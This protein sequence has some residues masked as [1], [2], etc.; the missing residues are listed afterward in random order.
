MPKSPPVESGS[1]ERS[2]AVARVLAALEELSVAP[3]PLSNHELAS[4][5]GVPSA[6]MYRL[7][8]KL[9]ELGYVEH[10]ATHASYEVAP[11]LADLAERLA[12]AGC[13][14]PPLRRLLAALRAEAGDHIAIWVRSGIQVRVAALL[15]GE[16]R[17]PSSSA[18]R[19]LPPF[20]TPGLAIASQYTREQVRALVAQCRRRRAPFGRRFSGIADIEKTLRDVRQRGF[21]VGYNMRSDGW[22]ILAWPVVVTAAPLRIGALTI[23]AP[24]ATLRREEARLVQVAQRLVAGYHREQ[25]A[26]GPRP[27]P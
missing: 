20:S 24:V 7:L 2:R 8:Q 26:A 23:G 16:V 18:F 12:D 25:A 5:L 27:L 9:A 10:S 13:R 17:G 21:A 6:S 4:R 1:R 15:V 19:E 22:G 14:A 3:S 11:R